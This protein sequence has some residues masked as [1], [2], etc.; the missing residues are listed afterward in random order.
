M[1]KIIA[2]F[3]VA[4]CAL[5]FAGTALAEEKPVDDQKLQEQESVLFDEMPVSKGDVYL[6]PDGEEVDE[7]A[8]GKCWWWCWRRPVVYTYYPR[9]YYYYWY[10]PCYYTS[11]RVVTV[12]V[13]A[14]VA[15][16]TTEA[17][18]TTTTTTETQVVKSA[19]RVIKGAVIDKAIGSQ[20]PLRKHGLRRGDVI[21]AIDGQAVNTLADVKRAKAD[22]V[23]SYVRGNQ[24]KVAGNVLERNASPK[25]YDAADLVEF[26]SKDVPSKS[27]LREKSMTLYEYYDSLAE[28]ENQDEYGSDQY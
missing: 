8:T 6:A 11:F 15:T 5:M 26:D 3:A 10:C 14:T 9:Y 13:P 19:N 1:K 23:I 18:T 28:T 16:V 17:A 24:V 2:S 21:T 7:Q 25:G 27:T 4:A 22:S 20:S 12:T